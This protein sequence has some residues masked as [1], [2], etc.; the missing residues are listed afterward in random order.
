PLHVRPRQIPF[1]RGGAGGPRQVRSHRPCEEGAGGDGR[2]GGRPQGDRQRDQEDRRRGSRLR[3]AGARAGSGR[4]LHRRAGG[5]L[6]MPIELKMPA[7]SPTMEEGTLAKWLVKEG[8]T[9]SAGD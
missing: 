9:V 3:R 8:D 6:L 4:A 2:E 5:E 1:A 7:L